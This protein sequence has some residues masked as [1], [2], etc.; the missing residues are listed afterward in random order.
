MNLIIPILISSTPTLAVLIVIARK[1]VKL[2]LTAL[3]GG[4]GWLTALLLR[5][6]LLLMFAGIGISYAYIASLLAGIFEEC[7]R[8]TLL[9]V[10]FIRELS[11]RGA[12]SLGLG[13]GLVESLI[14][15]L[16]PAY[17]AG[18]T[19]SYSWLDLLPGAIERNSAV[20]IHVSL[21][22]LLSRDVKDLRLLIIAI[23]LHTLVNSVAVTSLML[24]KDVWLVEGLIALM[25]LLIST[26][27]ILSTLRLR[28]A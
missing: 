16:I 6:P 24:L 21:S 7:L 8:L 19:M 10:G 26:L 2:W 23:V 14:I 1:Y 3:L 25:T 22:L 13:W 9:R 15:Y 28:K 11:V 12:L 27:I 4:G 18:V 5:Q 17:V 20:M